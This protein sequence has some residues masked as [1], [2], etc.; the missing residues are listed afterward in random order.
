MKKHSR[1]FSVKEQLNNIYYASKAF[2]LLRTSKKTKL[3]NKKFKERIML[4]VT[5]VNGCAMCSFVHTKLALQSGM[6]RENIQ[7]LL[8]GD[9]SM[10]P[11]EESVAILFGQHF[12]SSKESPSDEAIDRLIQEYGLQK[13]ELVLAACNMITMTNAMGI[14]LDNLYNRIKFN[15]VQGSKLYR[16]LLNPFLV[17]LL[18]PI[19]TILYFLMSPF[20]RIKLLKNK[21]I[22]S[23]T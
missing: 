17:M 9:T 21:Y 11:L 23:S 8:G 1:L 7:A 5:E 10:V 12:A 4:A 3:M 22:I 18:F 14:G 2:V 6:S 16:E 15:R 19:L 13:A 20:K